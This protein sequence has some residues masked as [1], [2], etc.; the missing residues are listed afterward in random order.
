MRQN[1]LPAQHCT[2]RMETFGAFVNLRRPIL[3]ID[4]AAIEA[5]LTSYQIRFTDPYSSVTSVPVFLTIATKRL[6][7]TALYSAHG[8]FRSICE[9]PQTNIG[10]RSRRN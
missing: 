1:D 2:V 6:T 10:N 7:D 9:S 8:N 5:S 4:L 3:G